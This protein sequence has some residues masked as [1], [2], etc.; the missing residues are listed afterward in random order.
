[1]QEREQEAEAKR[2]ARA[3]EATFLQLLRGYTPNGITAVSRAGSPAPGAAGGSDLEIVISEKTTYAEVQNALE[4]QDAWK[5][6][7]AAPHTVSMTI[8]GFVKGT[9]QEPVPEMWR[10]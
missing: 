7:W 4:E 10:H 1:M 8:E 9:V 2:A 3:A 6:S 5:V